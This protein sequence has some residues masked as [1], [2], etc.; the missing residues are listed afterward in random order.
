MPQR[1]AVVDNLNGP[2][3]HLSRFDLPHTLRLLLLLL[4]TMLLLLLL[5]L[6]SLLALS[7]LLLLLLICYW[8]FF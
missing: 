1:V 2:V 5:L 3:P 7:L 6:L 4:L 8:H